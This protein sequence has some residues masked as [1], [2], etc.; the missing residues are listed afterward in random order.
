MLTLLIVMIFGLMVVI[1]A[2][3]FYWISQ[4]N[5]ALAARASKLQ[6]DADAYQA[7]AHRLRSRLEHYADTDPVAATL[8]DDMNSVLDADNS[9]KALPVITRRQS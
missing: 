7:L 8:L 6:A 9:V 3:G 5:P 2:T 4:R 1:A